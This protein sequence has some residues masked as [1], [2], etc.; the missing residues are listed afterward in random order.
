M[1]FAGLTSRIGFALL[2]IVV[3][4]HIARATA[5]E[6]PRIA[7]I[8]GN[9][10]YQPDT[11]DATNLSTDGRLPRLKNACRDSEAVAAAVEKLG[12]K[13]DSEIIHFCDLPTSGI[14][15]E[16]TKFLK[17][18]ADNP[19]AV[20][21]FYYAGHGVQVGARSYLFGI[22]AKPN[23][24]TAARQIDKGSEAQLFVGD[25]IDVYQDFIIKAGSIT[26]GGFT[27]L[28]DACRSDPVVN[29]L[30]PKD[31]L[32]KVTAPS[33]KT[34]ILDGIL[35]GYSTQ[36]GEFAADGAGALG[37]YAEALVKHI[38]PGRPITKTMLSVTQTV[39]T[40][41]RQ[42][43]PRNPQVPFYMGSSPYDCLIGCN[44]DDVVTASAPAAKPFNIGKFANLSFRGPIA[45][46][47]SDAT[48]AM[49][50]QSSPVTTRVSASP[51]RT[52]QVQVVFDATQAGEKNN[53]FGLR[54]DVFWCDGVS[55][56]Q[57]NLAKARKVAAYLGE[58]GLKKAIG[59]ST[60][61]L[62]SLSV[63]ANSKPAY[64]YLTNNVIYD[65]GDAAEENVKNRLI[66]HF[67][68]EL[69]PLTSATR[70]PAYLSTFI[71]KTSPTTNAPPSVFW[72]VAR[73][74]QMALA[75]AVR[76]RIDGTRGTFKVI[77]GIE[78]TEVSP[79]NTE[80]RFFS[81][82]TRIAA[83]QLADSLQIILGHSVDTKFIPM[84]K[85]ASGDGNVEVWIG[86]LESAVVGV[87]N[88]RGFESAANKG[89][90][91]NALVNR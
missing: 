17:F 41:T 90:S 53:R 45:R 5:A 59:I 60:V 32:R 66:E 22:D 34:T 50:A 84:L 52:S 70:S 19:E 76:G 46:R 80:I 12:W 58:L 23:L 73:P 61:R 89:V 29:A 38:A 39:K 48:P 7:L 11:S 26:D 63:S 62:R 72:Q 24:K 43:D 65:F 57:E 8:I 16:I 91:R 4:S 18:V 37:P 2:L 77:D 51:A 54:A 6:R 30:N 49:F 44:D 69:Q 47:R 21:L 14:S 9:T 56:A 13:P 36:D 87:G 64:R 31:G 78:V 71:C 74:D 88:P 28:I 35:I 10:A 27:I 42:L 55:G 1:N 68:D 85:E 40:K 15:T 79:D 3:T 81:A 20:A 67:P 83:Y 82:V 86:R 25:A 33:N 75:K